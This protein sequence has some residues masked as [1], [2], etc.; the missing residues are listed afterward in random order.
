M[1]RYTLIV[2]LVVLSVFNLVGT[3][4]Q[5]T[6]ANVGNLGCQSLGGCSGGALCNSP[7]EAS[8][9]YIACNN[10][11]QISCPRS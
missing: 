3:M 11:S 4:T 10:G 7:G 9:C 6:S 8:G 1:K 2:I 5:S